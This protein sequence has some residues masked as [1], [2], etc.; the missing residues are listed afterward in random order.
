MRNPV[1]EV[2]RAIRNDRLGWLEESRED[3]FVIGD[4]QRTYDNRIHI[5]GRIN[6]WMDEAICLSS[7][8]DFIR[9]GKDVGKHKRNKPDGIP[10]FDSTK[11]DTQV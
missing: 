6:E 7:V 1:T 5:E 8:E 9:E 2:L 3:T 11:T 10:G 4:P